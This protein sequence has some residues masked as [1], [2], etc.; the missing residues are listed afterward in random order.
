[1]AKA[2]KKISVRGWNEFNT[3]S[4]LIYPHLNEQLGY[5]ERKT[6]YFDEQTWVRKRGQKKGPY[7]GAFKNN[8]GVIL[9]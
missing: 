1:M 4:K 3:F 6:K 8:N 2:R 5:P 7:D 9:R